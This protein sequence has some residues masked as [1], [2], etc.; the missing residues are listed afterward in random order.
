MYLYQ[1]R[2]VNG[3][4]LVYLELS[5]LSPFLWLYDWI[6]ELFWHFDIFY[7]SYYENE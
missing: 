3:R 2:E 4:V 6:L 7:L 1:A 5:I